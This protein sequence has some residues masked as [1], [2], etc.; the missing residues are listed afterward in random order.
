MSQHW[1]TYKLG[2]VAEI[3]NGFAFKSKDLGE[4]GVPVIKIK[5]VTPPNVDLSDSQSYDGLIDNRMEKYIINEGDLLIAMTGSTVNVMSS[6]VGKMG[7][8]RIGEPALLNQRVGKIY[9]V[10]EDIADYDFLCHYLNRYE[11]HYNLALNATGSANQANISPAQIKDLDINLPPLPEQQAIAEILSSLDDKIELNLQM[12]KTLEEMAMTLYKHW[13]VDFG[14]FQDGEF[15]DSELG[16]IPKGWE[17]TRLGEEFEVKIG[18]TPPRKEKQWFSS[19]KGVK[20]VSIKD[21]GDSGMYISD[22]SEFL[23]EEAVKMKNVPLVRPNVV[24]M[25]F[26]LT[27]GRVAITTQHMA[28]NEAIAQFGIRGNSRLESQFLYLILKSYDFDSLGSTSS[29]ATAINSKTVKD[30]KIL[31]PPEEI[32]ISFMNRVSDLM[33]QVRNGIFENKILIK[34]R[35]TLLPKLISG[36]VRV[37]EA[38]R[39]VGEVV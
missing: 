33:D 28:T 32:V 14:P 24:L 25:S 2:D 10:R 22:S 23:T 26:K 1:K 11:V 7:R 39:M 5:N 27:V 21:M 20:W 19:E 13:F 15:V 37:K 31:V 12:N 8:Y 35:D 3:Q 16:K 6:A 36:E 30:I 18:R 4:I 9:L 38:E 29:I 34:T 17:I